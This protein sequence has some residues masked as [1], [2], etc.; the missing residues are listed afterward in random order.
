MLDQQTYLARIGYEGSV[1]P[2]VE[3][4]RLL[5]RAHVLTV[6]FENL[7]IHLGRSISLDPSAL[8]RKIVLS[9]RGGYCFELNGLFAL[10][11]EQLGFSVTR[12]AARVLYGAEGVSPRSHQLLLVQIGESQWMADVG[13][14][15]NALREPF[16]LAIGHEQ[17]QG[18][19]GFRLA[20][21]ERGEYLLQ[22]EIEGAWENLYSFTLDPCLTVDYI[23]ANYYHS[24]SPDSPF[25]QR[26]ICTIPTMGGR[27][28]FAGRLLKIRE[29]GTMEE[30]HV[31]DEGR[32]KQLLRQYFEVTIKDDLT[33]FGM[34]SQ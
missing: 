2:S 19:D 16:L 26:R 24:H 25:T 11:L 8:F 9:R 34:D 27:K 3:T 28:I 7:D 15:G 10:L 14:G 1:N 23:F 6:P 13:F 21:N 31:K 18:P 33:L 32:L 29:N 17:R 4:L 30:L 5:H 22:C 20:T 12:L